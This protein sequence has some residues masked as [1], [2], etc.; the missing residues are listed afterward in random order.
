V[1][2]FHGTPGYRRNPW[3]IGAELRSAGVRLIAPDRPGG[4]PL[5]AA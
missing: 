4:G 2:F 3:T 1:L 5:G